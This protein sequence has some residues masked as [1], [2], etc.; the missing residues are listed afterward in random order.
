MGPC[1][2]D[3]FVL[4]WGR[5]SATMSLDQG[6]MTPNDDA[7]DKHASVER[8]RLA[9]GG[10]IL[11]EPDGFRLIEPRGLK[12]SPLHNYESIAHLY[13]TD[14]VLL[15]GT[16]DGLLSVRSRDFTSGTAGSKAALQAL[17]S[18]IF[19]RPEGMQQ[20]RDMEGV[21]R[22]GER[23][24]P[25]WVIWT[26]VALCLLGML[27]QLRDPSVRDVGSFLPE[28]FGRGE[29][30][31]AI[32]SHFVHALTPTPDFLRALLPGFSVLPIHLAVNVGGM[33]VLGYLVER[34]MGSWRT[35]L[36]MS[37]SAVGTIIGILIAGHV[38]VVGSSGIVAGLAGSM[39][40][41][42]LH[43]SRWLPGFWRL[44]RR[45]FIVVIVVQFAVID[46]LFAGLLA[47]GAHLGG[48]VGGYLSTWILG[49]PCLEAL[50]PT[51]AQR[52]G[53]LAAA[54]LA[55][56][57]LVG[58]LPLARQDMAALE[59]HGIRLLNSE[60]AFYLYEY[61]NAAAWLIATE[62]S[63]SSQGLQLA[64][65][66]A[67]RAVESTRRLHPDV[68][69]TLAEALFQA[70]DPLGAVLTI[71]EAIRLQPREPYFFE[72]WRRFTGARDPA[73]R[74]PPPGSSVLG[75]EPPVGERLDVLPILDPDAKRVTI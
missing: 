28:L 44:P 35:A 70:G 15:I 57:G 31:R 16:T 43:F 9:R 65:A 36:I 30:W 54:L 52:L 21:D 41:M 7:D 67:D 42:E 48:F 23:D 20:L 53:V 39:L 2:L 51:P 46:Q 40:A 63:A 60:Q 56:M 3:W 25:T 5:Y 58:A 71:E 45:I 1:R 59:R 61:E 55:V 11:L 22:L 4:S 13:Q 26:T 29:Y 17:R 24:G 19:E 69:D 6:S 34:P 47:G 37:F 18:R 66:L 33:L 8:I 14:R 12:R 38:N 68:L 73:D 75:D 62:G 27:L 49:R 32:T 64:V 50:E 72:Q 10:A 74:P